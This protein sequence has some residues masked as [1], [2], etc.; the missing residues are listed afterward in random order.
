MRV[1]NIYVNYNDNS[2][3]DNNLPRCGHQIYFPVQYFHRFLFGDL[4]IFFYFSNCQYRLLP[5][6]MPDGSFG[7]VVAR[8]SRGRPSNPDR[9]GC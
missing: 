2:T 7:S 1:T 9:V 3:G 6:T 5:A 8:N 4:V